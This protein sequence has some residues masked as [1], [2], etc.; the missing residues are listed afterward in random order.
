MQEWIGQ[1]ER[2]R[3]VELDCLPF[4]NSYDF[5]PVQSGLPGLISAHQPFSMAR[6]PTAIWLGLL[7]SSSSSRALPT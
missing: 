1:L 3:G 6:S 4:M 2:V 5:V 7:G